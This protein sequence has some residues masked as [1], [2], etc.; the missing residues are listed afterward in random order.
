MKRSGADP[1]TMS[2][3]SQGRSA[4]QP[5]QRSFQRTTVPSTND[6]AWNEGD[7]LMPTTR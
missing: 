5:T 4:E 2:T 3:A 1:R 6:S 7:P